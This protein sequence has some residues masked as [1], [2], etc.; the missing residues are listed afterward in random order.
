MNIIIIC[1]FPFPVGYS[2]TNRIISYSK[3]LIELGCKVKVLIIRRT[4]NKNNIKNKDNKGVFEG[5]EYE[6]TSKSNIKSNSKF[7]KAVYLIKDIIASY[8]KLFKLAKINP[9]DLLLISSDLC[10]DIFLFSRLN[11]INSIKKVFWIVDEYPSPIRYGSKSI[12]FISSLLYKNSLKRLNGLISMTKVVRDFYKGI[13]DFDFPSL[14]MPITVELENFIFPSNYNQNF[15][16]I[17]YIGNMEIYKDNLDILIESFSL[18]CKERND[19]KLWLVGE[20]KDVHILKQKVDQMGLSNCVVFKGSKLRNEIPEILAIS[21]ILVLTRVKNTRSD[22]G[23][24]T[25]LG[26]YLASGKPVILTNVGEINEYIID[27]V[28][29]FLVEPNNINAFSKCLLYVANHYEEAMKVGLEGR[30]LAEGVFNY[31]TQAIRM[32]DFFLRG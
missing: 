31:K 19:Y 20:G 30:K 21:S 13:C 25:K 4:E 32:Y 16:I 28:N 10:Y 3:G 23:F 1:R 15:K 27:Q 2:G 26:E 18:F 24:P 11:N 29:A 7:S 12:S 17:T 8:I 14:I 9:I 5:I 6:Y 22:G